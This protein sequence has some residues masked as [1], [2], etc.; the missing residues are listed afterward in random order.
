MKILNKT[1]FRVIISLF[2]GAFIQEIIHISTGDPNRPQGAN[3]T[4]IYAGII[5]LLI[6]LFIKKYKTE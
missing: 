4:L 1:W 3:L 5:Y 2:L 6:T